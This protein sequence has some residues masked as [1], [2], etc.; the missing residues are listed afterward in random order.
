MKSTTDFKVEFLVPG[1][2]SIKE[3]ELDVSTR[4]IKI[5]LP[6]LSKRREINLEKPVNVDSVKAKLLKKEG[7]L[8]VILPF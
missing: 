8:S 6:S 7:K 5:S 3:V 4:C 1:I 2:S